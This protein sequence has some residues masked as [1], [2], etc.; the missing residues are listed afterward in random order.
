MRRVRADMKV[1]RHFVYPEYGFH[2]TAFA[3][4]DVNFLRVI[5]E[6]DLVSAQIVLN[7]EAKNYIYIYIYDDE[8]FLLIQIKRK[9]VAD[10]FLFTFA[11]DI[12]YGNVQ[13]DWNFL[14][15]LSAIVNE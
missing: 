1:A 12:K 5:N 3:I 10:K 4:V 15:I 9:K 6:S 8:I 7:V 2:A 11:I 14:I 13:S